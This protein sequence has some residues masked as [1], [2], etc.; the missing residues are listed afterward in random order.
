[1]A[2][3]LRIA[4]SDRYEVS[5]KT[6]VWKKGPKRAGPLTH[7]RI[8]AHGFAW[9]AAYREFLRVATP[10]HAAACLGVFTKLLEV[11]ANRDLEQRWLIRSRNSGN[12]GKCGKSGSQYLANL[13]RDLGFAV[14]DVERAAQVLTHK[15]VAWLEWIEVADESDEKDTSIPGTPGIP[16][17]CMSVCMSSLSSLE[18]KK[19]PPENPTAK[20]EPKP[21][22]DVDLV[23]AHYRTRHPKVRVLSAKVRGLIIK[24]LAETYSVDDLRKAIDGNFVS[25]FHCGQND[26]QAEYH[27]LG[28]IVR[29]SEKVQM[30]IDLADAAGKPVL[31]GKSQLTVRA[32]ES[33][34]QRKLKG[35]DDEDS[36]DLPG[37]P[38]GRNQ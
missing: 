8:P 10:R 32:A 7:V 34:K 18:S 30:F 27:G 17:D 2:K 19:A 4:H 31:D 29:D 25:P 33:F 35:C 14:I 38:K 16:G 21:P 22:S 37:Q 5:A 15:D 26:K 3:I 20:T 23:W 1:M 36:A 6:G 28:L 9:S 12:P 13:A 24:R 11:G